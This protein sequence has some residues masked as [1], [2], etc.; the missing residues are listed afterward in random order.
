MLHCRCLQTELRE[1]NPA[2]LQRPSLVLLN[3]VDLPA[4]SGAFA[5]VRAATLL[6]VVTARYGGDV[7]W[8]CRLQMSKTNLDVCVCVCVCETR[9][10]KQRTNIGTVV[11]SIRWLLE[12]LL[13]QEERAAMA[14]KLL[15]DLGAP[16]GSSPPRSDVAGLDDEAGEGAA[17]SD[18][19]DSDVD[20]SD[21][22]DSDVDESGQDAPSKDPH[23]SLDE[24][25]QRGRRRGRSRK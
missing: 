1:Y 19:D 14:T 13:K 8:L 21:V 2:L 23:S 24:S 20:D 25:V 7:Q 22:D 6:P 17:S 10:A 5:A 3:K 4:A 9:S 11:S 18:D 12:S 15:G 16:G